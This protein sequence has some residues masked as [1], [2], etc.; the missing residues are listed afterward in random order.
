V[1]GD[2]DTAMLADAGLAKEEIETL[3]V[4]AIVRA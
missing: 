1:I 4:N 2:H 3:L